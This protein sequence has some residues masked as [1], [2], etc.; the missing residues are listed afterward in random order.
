MTQSRPWHESITTYES[1]W[2][3]DYCL[4][5]SAIWNSGCGLCSIYTVSLVVYMAIVTSW[6]RWAVLLFV[7]FY[8]CE[9]YTTSYTF[10]PHLMDQEFYGTDPWLTWPVD[11]FDPWF[12]TRCP[13]ICSDTVAQNIRISG[14]SF[15]FVVQRTLLKL[16]NQSKLCQNALKNIRKARLQ[17]GNFKQTG[18]KIAIFLLLKNIP[19][20][21]SEVKI[22]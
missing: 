4:L 8:E 18:T 20:L 15:E 14:S 1:W 11:P 17:L 10:T 19:Y 22:E 9:Q 21:P 13:S 3:H 16:R 12:M 2:V 5:F 6:T 7:T